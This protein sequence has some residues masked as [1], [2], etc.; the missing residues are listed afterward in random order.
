MIAHGMSP[1][2]KPAEASCSR[3]P[4][5]DV[6]LCPIARPTP[7]ISPKPTALQ[8][9]DRTRHDPGEPRPPDDAIIL[10]RQVHQPSRSRR[11]ETIKS[12]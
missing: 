2:R 12:P 9:P 7:A 3:Q 6:R 8:P 4:V 10:I 1:H 5:D 11:R